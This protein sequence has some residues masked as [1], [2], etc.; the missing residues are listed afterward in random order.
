MDEPMDRQAA[1][2]EEASVD[3]EAATPT[4]RLILK[5]NGAETEVDFVVHPPSVVGRFDPDVG[6]ID[7]DL[8]L[9]PEGVYVSRR[10]ARIEFADG[11]W[12]IT[13]LGSS[14][15]TFLL[16]PSAGQFERIQEAELADGSELAF[17]NVRFVFR[18][19]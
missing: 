7:I 4:A 8:G 12:R 2:A 11:A 6:P 5:R 9:L 14:N 19:G 1:E 15:G 16:K 3:Q 10:H 17:G 18:V 13:D